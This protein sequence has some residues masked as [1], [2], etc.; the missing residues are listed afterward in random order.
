MPAPKTESSLRT[1]SRIPGAPPTRRHLVLAG[2]GHS[3][4]HVLKSLAMR[5]EPDTRVTVISP[6]PRAIYSGM[7]PGTLVGLYEDREGAI[8]VSALT[9]RCGG[10]FLRDRVLRVDR[11][12][13][14][15]VAEQRGEIP[16]DLLSL[17]V[18]SRPRGIARFA[19]EP[20]IVGVKPVE[21]AAPRIAA[22]LASARQNGAGRVV[23]VGAGAGGVEVAFA[24]RQRLANG[25]VSLIESSREVLPGGSPR[26]QRLLRS[27]VHRYGIRAFVERRF[28]SIEGSRVLLDDGTALEA[29]LVVWATGAEGL[30]W[31]AESGFSVDGQG[32]VVV[33]DSLRSVDDP[34]IFATGDCARM[35]S[36]PEMPRAGVYAVRQ[37]PILEENL[38][39]S[40]R[41]RPLLR[42]HPQSDFLSLISTGDGRA[43]MSYRGL[44]AH[45]RVFWQLK[46]WIDRRFI[47]KYRPPHATELRSGPEVAATMPMEPCGGCAAKV[48][49]DALARVLRGLGAARGAG[50][51]IGL[52]APD[53][54][55]VL[56]RPKS[57]NLVFTVDA[58]PPFL[59]DPL[60]VGEIAALNAVSD[61]YAMGGSPT[62]ALALVGV[63]S[64]DGAARESDLRQM[65]F[66]AER[67]LASLDVALAGGHSIESEAPLIGF[68]ILGSVEDGQAL[69][70]AGVE[71]GDRLVLTKALGTGVVLAA[72]RAGECPME[73]SEATV[74]EMRRAND[75]AAACFQAAG[76]RSC[77]DVSGFGLAGHLG[78]MLRASRLACDVAI[79]DV[80][81]LPGAL[82][83][84]RR[85]W[86][87]SADENLADALGRSIDPGE[88]LP[89]DPR[90][91]LLRDPQT[92]GGLIAAVPQR[93]WKDV[94]LRLETAGVGAYTIGVAA[95]G[96]PG[97]LRIRE[98]ALDDDGSFGVEPSA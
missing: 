81:A 18:G 65:M 55:A 41:G 64:T 49:P 43:A 35:K 46:D 27:L 45:G 51:P 44:A 97:L 11:K 6:D 74:A 56:P 87:S 29:D 38:R 66:G 24:L 69:T 14:V 34:A 37:G 8:D 13:Q 10:T 72:T 91:A 83:L 48:D 90:I 1:S 42:Y 20:R 47:A 28:A 2:G 75:R 73:W 80:P 40:L 93:C 22:F 53:D 58:F 36:H 7:V 12:R 30:P 82:E 62:A 9:A 88:L 32:F 92:S 4:V 50:L 89:D 94:V 33:D 21:D 79:D 98:E 63:P 17:D 26:M 57:G 96:P 95:E 70:K 15:V 31:L 5:P 86:R 61:V 77:T 68:A 25:T 60:L 3:H 76:V 67:T 19:G 54:A 59:P 16:F 52:E 39:R 71:V 84:L 78:E 85:D 23:V